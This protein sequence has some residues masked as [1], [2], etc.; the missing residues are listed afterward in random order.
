MHREE[1]KYLEIE[2][3]GRLVELW[4]ICKWGMGAGKEYETH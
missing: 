4:K 2:R 1:G 3:S